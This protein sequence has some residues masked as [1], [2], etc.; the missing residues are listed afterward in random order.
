MWATF[1]ELTGA[2]LENR[3]GI[4]ILPALLGAPAGARE[5]DFLYW[6]YHSQGGAQAVRAGRWK[7]IRNNAKA[8]PNG[9]L[10]LY[11]LETDPSEKADVSARHPDIVRRIVEM[12]RKS[13]TPSHLQQWNF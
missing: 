10:E 5:H 12:M 7:G 9:P 2:P 11:D 1:A 13:H 6:E 4:S 3:D 8:N